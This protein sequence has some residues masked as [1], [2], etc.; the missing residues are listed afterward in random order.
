MAGGTPQNLT[1]GAEDGS[2]HWAPIWSPD[3][4]RL[5]LLSTRSGNVRAWVCDASAR[6][7]HRLCERGVDLGSHA[8]PMGWVS[9]HEILI[10][11]LPEGERPGR[12]TV[13]IAAAQIAMREWPKA[14]RGLEP[15]ASVLESGVA[16][17]FEVR[18]QGAL[19]LADATAGTARTAMRGL[20][21][22]LRIAPD[23]RHVAFFRQVDVRRR[24]RTSG[25]SGWVATSSGSES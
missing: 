5:A 18:P 16:Q 25:S 17:R 7:L 13:E 19:V 10:A 14:W 4:K 9:D 2:G 11:T 8:A 23:R 21:R 12:M 15:T 20:F 1:R 24:A 22:D 3:S 6:T